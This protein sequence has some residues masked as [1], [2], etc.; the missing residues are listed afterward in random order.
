MKVGTQRIREIV[1]SLR[2]FS[3]IDEA[4][5][6]AV[7]IHEG[8]N[9]TIMILQHRLKAKPEHPEI[10][11]IR[12]Y[13]HLPLI[14]CYAGQLNQ[15]F[16]NIVANAIDA[17]EEMNAHRTYQQMHDHPSCIII[18]TSVVDAQSVQIAIADNG[19]GIPEEIQQRIFDPFFTT[20]P[21]GKGT[22]MGMSISYQIITEKHHGKLECFSKPGEGTKFAIKIPIRQQ[23]HEAIAL[24]NLNFYNIL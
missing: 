13:G 21:V 12:E 22:G 11:V 8:I 6:K 16:M 9:S 15:A 7:D 2:N 24:S 18:S 10:S 23:A 14:E 20:K 19:P 5:C 1:R 3:R 4:E 17:L